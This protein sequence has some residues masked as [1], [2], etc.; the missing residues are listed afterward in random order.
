VT[1][2]HLFGFERP[3]QEELKLKLGEL[4][5]DSDIPSELGH[6]YTHG[7]DLLTELPYVR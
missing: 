4:F 7:I 3:T 6:V 2:T 5:P 1:K